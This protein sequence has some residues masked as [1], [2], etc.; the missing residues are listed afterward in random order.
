[1]RAQ[2]RSDWELI[3]VG[4]A[5]TDDTAD[6]VATFPDP[7]IRFVNLPENVGEQSG[8]N[9]EGVRLGH[10]RRS[11]TPTGN[12]GGSPRRNCRSGSG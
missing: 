11:Q 10:G 5:C 8:P 7:R 2:T 6:V 9:N 1:V 4:D 3:V 12:P